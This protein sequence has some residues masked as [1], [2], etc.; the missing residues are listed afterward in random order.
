M[1]PFPGFIFDGTVTILLKFCDCFINV[2]F[3]YLRNNFEV[4]IKDI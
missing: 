1:M 3:F 4:K 2:S